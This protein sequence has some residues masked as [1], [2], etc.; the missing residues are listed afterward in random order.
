VALSVLLQER[1]SDTIRISLTPEPAETAARSGGAQET[2]QTMGLR[3]FAPL[4]IIAPVAAAPHT[5]FQNSPRA[6]AYLRKPMPL[7][8]SN[9]RAWKTCSGGDGSCERPR[10]IE[11]VQHRHQPAASASA[12]GAGIRSTGER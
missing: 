7:L 8:A 3:P 4:V 12:G 1:H 2:L 11:A 5:Y 9:F 10:R 6:S